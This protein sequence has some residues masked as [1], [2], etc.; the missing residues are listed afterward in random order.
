MN[1]QVQENMVHNIVS[2]LGFVIALFNGYEYKEVEL[3]FLAYLTSALNNN[4]KV[5]A[6]SQGI[7]IYPGG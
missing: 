6:R 1:I 3:T 2:T 7:Y 4:F 5:E